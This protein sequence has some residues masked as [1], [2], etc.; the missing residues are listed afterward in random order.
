MIENNPAFYAPSIVD[1]CNIAIDPFSNSP[2]AT[3]I[4]TQIHVLG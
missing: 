1:C 4:V 3:T 2:I